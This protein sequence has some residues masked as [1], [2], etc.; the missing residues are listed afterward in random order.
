MPQRDFKSF[1]KGHGL[2]KMFAT[3]A[4]CLQVVGGMT[5]IR[6]LSS[7]KEMFLGRFCLTG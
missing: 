4:G 3:G 2:G 5:N 1:G 7:V 6:M